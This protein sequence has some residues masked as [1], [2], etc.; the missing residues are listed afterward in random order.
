MTAVSGQSLNTHLSPFTIHRYK[1][2]ELLDGKAGT[3]KLFF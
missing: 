2:Y 3:G 1:Y